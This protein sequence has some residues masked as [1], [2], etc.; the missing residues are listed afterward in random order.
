MAPQWLPDSFLAEMGV[1][2]VEQI[3]SFEAQRLVSPLQLPWGLTARE[4]DL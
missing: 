4:R 1:G 2:G 3:F